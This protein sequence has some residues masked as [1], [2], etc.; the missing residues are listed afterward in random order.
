MIW[1]SI[2]HV[3]TPWK[4]DINSNQANRALRIIRMQQCLGSGFGDSKAL[5]ILTVFM[6]LLKRTLVRGPISPKD[7]PNPNS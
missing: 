3:N 5:R 6:A 1:E 2:P 7:P 4:Q